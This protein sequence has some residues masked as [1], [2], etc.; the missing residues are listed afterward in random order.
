MYKDLV[1]LIPFLPKVRLAR[2]GKYKNR[3]GGIFLAHRLTASL[4]LMETQ[5]NSEK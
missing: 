1:P 5:P 2:L 3:I 4:A